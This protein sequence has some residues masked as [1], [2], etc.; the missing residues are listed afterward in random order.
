MILIREE[1][2]QDIGRIREINDAAFS[3][4]N[5]GQIVDW[6]R[7]SCLDTL[8][9]VA[10]MN[11]KI[12]GHIFFSPVEIESQSWI[13]KGMG[14]APMAVTPDY[15]N[16]GIGSQLV[17]EGLSKVKKKGYPFVVVLGY[18]AFYPRFGFQQASGLGLKCQWKDV[19]DEAFMAIIFNEEKMKGVAGV[20]RYRDEFDGAM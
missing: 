2:P 1:K 13:V 11:G 18:P 8:S 6:I 10:V 15:Q 19:P 17:C 3:Q 9:L 14:L 7:E 12:V 4:P 20:A 16:Q 5:E